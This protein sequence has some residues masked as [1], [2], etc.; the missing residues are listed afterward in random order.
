MGFSNA[1]LLR[2]VVDQLERKKKLI[3]GSLKR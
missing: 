3:G 2:E 1:L